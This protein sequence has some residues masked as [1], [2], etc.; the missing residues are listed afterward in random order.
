MNELELTRTAFILMMN[1]L[2]HQTAS[3]EFIAAVQQLEK[4]QLAKVMAVVVYFLDQEKLRTLPL[5]DDALNSQASANSPAGKLFNLKMSNRLLNNF[6]SINKKNS[7][8][9]CSA[10]EGF[11][12][13]ESLLRFS[14]QLVEY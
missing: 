2:L 11:S 4:V 5:Y 8:I 10:L 9:T 7:T 13:R 3:S 14:I 12:S 6:V 1:G